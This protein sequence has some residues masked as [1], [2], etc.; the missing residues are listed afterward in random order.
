MHH[1]QVS[2]NCLFFRQ[3]MSNPQGTSE[4]K[5]SST[6]SFSPAERKIF[7]VFV[8]YL[9]SGALQLT[10]FSIA[11]KHINHDIDAIASYF[12]C[13]RSGYDSACSLEIAQ[14]PVWA[15]LALIVLLLLPAINF[16]YAIRGDDFKRFCNLC[17]RVS[18]VSLLLNNS[19]ATSS[20]PPS[21]PAQELKSCTVRV[22]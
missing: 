12:S 13:Q 15:L 4:R 7:I 3:H 2:I 1:M 18:R 6:I 20:V 8:Y 10:T 17:A 19:T 11:T 21:D 9:G 16:V 14:N 22:E 5:V